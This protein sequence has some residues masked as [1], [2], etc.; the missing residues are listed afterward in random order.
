[1]LVSKNVASL[2]EGSMGASR[3]YMTKRV[4]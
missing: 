1:M 2:V 3:V 4:E